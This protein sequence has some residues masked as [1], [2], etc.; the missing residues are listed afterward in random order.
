MPENVYIFG[1]SRTLVLYGSVR[2]DVIV[3]LLVIATIIFTVES[4]I[5]V[6][7]TVIVSDKKIADA[8]YT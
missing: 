8:T 7:D 5:I 4:T 3:F 6:S 1:L 2:T